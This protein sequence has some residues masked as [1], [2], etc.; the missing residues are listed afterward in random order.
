MKK[1]LLIIGAFMLS[2]FVVKAQPS[3]VDK[4]TEWA[5]NT[6][7]LVSP[8]QQYR[9]SYQGDGN[10]VVYDKS[11]SPLWDAKTY[12]TAPSKLVF[13]G[14]GN[15]VLYG[16]N[17]SV[18]WASYSH[19]KGGISLRLSD[20][21]ILSVWDDKNSIWSTVIPSRVDKP[22]EWTPNT[23]VLL[24]T[25]KQFRLSYQGDGN[26]VVYDKS[27]K[28]LWDARTCGTAPNKL[29]FQGDG[30]LVLYGANNS[31]FWASYS[32][33]KGGISLRLS[34]DGILSVWDDKNSIWST[35]I[36]SRVDKPTEWTPN[37]TVLVSPNKLYRLSYQGDGNLV[38][39]DNSN[40][41]LWD[42]KT[43]GT[44]PNKLVFQGDGNL[45]LYGVNNS[46]FWASYSHNKGG[47]SLRL[48]DQGSLSIWAPPSR[49]NNPFIAQRINKDELLKGLIG[50]WR[51]SDINRNEINIV[52][53]AD[54]AVFT[55]TDMRMQKR[56]VAEMTYT[57]NANDMRNP[58]LILDFSYKDKSGAISKLSMFIMTNEVCKFAFLK[59]ETPV[60]AEIKDLYEQT[61]M[62]TDISCIWHTGF[63]G[64]TK[65][66]ELYLKKYI[67]PKYKVGD[68][69]PGG[70]WIF[71]DKGDYTDGWRY[72]EAGPEDLGTLPWAL[73]TRN[74]ITTANRTALGTGKANTI[75][76]SNGYYCDRFYTTAARVCAEYQSGG[77]GGWYLPSIDELDLMY[78][79]LVQNLNVGN[80]DRKL[81]S[82]HWSSTIVS[83]DARY[84]Q[85]INF[86]NGG[87]SNTW[88]EYKCTVRP[89]RAFSD[90][91]D[92]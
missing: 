58:Y 71:Y 27:N 47:I 6:T 2:G 84:A 82:Y 8:N 62:R 56:I 11:N 41:P 85:Y 90:L 64:V 15:L 73:N 1:L 91:Q 74:L 53:T 81:G 7:V 69:G 92:W 4:P 35:V 59:Q 39:Y 78:V 10:L 37:T 76:I 50:E 89:I 21:G 48:N 26:L 9:L 86:K 30:N 28:P 83:K 40:K 70:G 66:N 23:T 17:N 45:V 33:N 42:A 44:A 72:L 87:H 14:D 65:L 32:H 22:T 25:N 20:D 51:G 43:Y 3:R 68:R 49:D 77:K 55:M 63:E 57:V 79:N 88:I 34:D 52:F 46:V 61:D 18:F 36:P 60:S 19:N 13:Q 5:P 54:K 38:V 12:G 24:S 16:A 29:V 67:V 80:F 31:V 75:E